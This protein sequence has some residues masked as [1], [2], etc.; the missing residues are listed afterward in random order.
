MFQMTTLEFCDA[1]EAHLDST[2]QETGAESKGGL[3]SCES[4]G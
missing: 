1:L 2:R 4:E 3:L